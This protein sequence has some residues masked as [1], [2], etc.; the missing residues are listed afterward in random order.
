MGLDFKPPGISDK[1]SFYKITSPINSKGFSKSFGS[2]F[3]WAENE[4]IKICFDD[5]I[6]YIKYDT[7]NPTYEMPKGAETDEEFEKSL[8][9]IMKHHAKTN[10]AAFKLK[11][12]LRH[13]AK[14]L[15]KLFPNKFEIVP[16][17]NDFE[18]IYSIKGLADLKGKKYHGKRGHI[19][20]FS[21]NN[22]WQYSPLNT[23]EKENY[24]KFFSS[25][26]EEK[27]GTNQNELK[28]IEKALDYYEELGLYGGAISVGEK[29]VAC[30]IGEKVNSETFVVHFEKA[31]EKFA[32]AYTVVN[33]ELCKHIQNEYRF[34]NRE[35]DLGIPGLRKAKLSYH[36]ISFVEKY[37]AV[38]K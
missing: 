8:N 17:R 14:K 28:S 16:Q 27:A 13:E 12:V 9:I 23:Q 20:K 1:N 6:L 25:W 11:R 32:D 30:A 34:I 31:L 2:Y 5:N 10:N 15:E 37:S 29:I 38:A 19:K 26:F 21:K 4:K 18:Y 33:N 35:D 22:E 36:P 3:L 24:I 7:E